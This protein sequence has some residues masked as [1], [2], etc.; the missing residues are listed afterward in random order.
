[1]EYI[2]N[3]E[4]KMQANQHTVV[5]ISNPVSSWVLIAIPENSSGKRLGT[6]GG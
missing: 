1:M 2:V 5:I 3:T 6:G 4:P